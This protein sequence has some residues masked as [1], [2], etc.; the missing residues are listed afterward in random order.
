VTAYN[1]GGEDMA[2]T[3]ISLHEQ[4][5]NLPNAQQ[6]HVLLVF[7]GWNKMS[8]S[9]RSYMQR[10]YPG[11]DAEQHLAM[12]QQAQGGASRR[13]LPGWM[14]EIEGTQ[15]ASWYSWLG[16]ARDV[17]RAAAGRQR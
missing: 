13:S 10:L 17:H 12:T 7:D 5:K 16:I 15:L 9:M 1:E 11:S 3:L 4:A 14:R 8:A 2:E 6:L